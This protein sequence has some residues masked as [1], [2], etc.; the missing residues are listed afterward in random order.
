MFRAGDVETGLSFLLVIRAKW[1]SSRLPDNA[2]PS[3][4]VLKPGVLVRVRGGNRTRDFSLGSPTVTLHSPLRHSQAHPN[5]YTFL[6][7]GIKNKKVYTCFYSERSAFADRFPS[8]TSFH[9]TLQPLWDTSHVADHMPPSCS[10]CR[11]FVE[12]ARSQ[13]ARGI[14]DCPCLLTARSLGWKSGGGGMGPCSQPASW[15]R[16]LAI[17]SEREN[18]GVINSC[19]VHAFAWWGR[20]RGWGWRGESNQREKGQESGI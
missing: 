3:S 1:R 9:G 8:L 7:K 10:C 19:P 15:D 20:G 4:L 17:K 13:S 14:V 11:T 2:L 5:T 12:L 18:N 16:H 6:S